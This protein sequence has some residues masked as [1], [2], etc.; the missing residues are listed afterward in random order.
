MPRVRLRPRAITDLEEI[1]DFIASDNPAAAASFIA[2]IMRCCEL[3]AATP[4]IGRDRAALH[5]NIR[6]FSVGR[7]VVF[8]N[9][10]A[11]GIEVVR[12]LHGAR[13]VQSL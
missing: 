8:Y 2:E 4:M 1:G 6:S 5:P 11:A 13:D 12:V 10:F 7:Y 9:P 3:L